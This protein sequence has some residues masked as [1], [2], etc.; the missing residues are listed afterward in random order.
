MGSSQVT[1]SQSS[2]RAKRLWSLYL[3]LRS[4]LPCKDKMCI[5]LNCLVKRWLR[6]CLIYTG[7]CGQI[8]T[9]IPVLSSVVLGYPASTV[10]NL[11]CV[12][13]FPYHSILPLPQMYTILT[14]S[15]STR[16]FTF[17]SPFF[18]SCFTR[19]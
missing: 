15:A 13:I 14:S 10:P 17:A 6:F 9:M 19:N 5:N 12:W 16:H 18:F 2:Q 11:K 1:C 3:F 4:R 7:H 8:S